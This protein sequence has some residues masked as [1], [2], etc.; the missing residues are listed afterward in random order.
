MGFE[1]HVTL[2]L[3][4]WQMNIS[5]ISHSTRSILQSL[6]ERYPQ[7]FNNGITIKNSIGRLFI[8]DSTDLENGSFPLCT[9]VDVSLLGQQFKADLKVAYRQFKRAYSQGSLTAEHNKRL[10]TYKWTQPGQ[11]FS[12]TKPTVIDDEGNIPYD[13]YALIIENTRHELLIQILLYLLFL[14][15][16]WHIEQ[17]GL[18]LHS[19]AVVHRSS[20]ES[21][22]FLGASG[23]GKTTVSRLNLEAGHTV[24]GDDIN[25]VI[26]D[27]AGSYKIAAAP[28]I[29]QTF[30][31]YSMLQP[32]LRGIFTLVKDDHDELIKL[33]P[34]KLAIALYKSLIQT[35]KAA[36]LPDYK[37]RKA[38]Q[39]IS[40]IARYIPGYE[41][42]F[43][44]KPDFWTLIDEQFSY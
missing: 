10:F 27:D 4:E 26:K 16:C 28:S 3:G 14:S 29:V 25:F 35:P 5:A 40:S 12:G 39:T 19:S 9:K 8:L 24:L 32:S 6:Q 17:G 22:L 13:L 1:R 42:H 38:F 7:F 44:K 21:F 33:F 11:K 36:S 34:R 18:Y 30:P 2:R 37:F 31:R 20:K 23:D 15:A 41:L 43:R